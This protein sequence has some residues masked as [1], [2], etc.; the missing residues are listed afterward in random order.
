[1]QSFGFPLEVLFGVLGLLNVPT[2]FG[3]FA[4]QSWACAFLS[5]ALSVGALSAI[6][7]PSLTL[8]AEFCQLGLDLDRL[9]DWDRL[10]LFSLFFIVYK[11]HL[12][13][14]RS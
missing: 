3:R 2:V 4:I 10:L 8:P 7:V 1:M 12:F 14:I 9:P 5:L 6:K 11:S 13:E